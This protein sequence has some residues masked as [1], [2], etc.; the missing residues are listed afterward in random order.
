[1][2]VDQMELP[3]YLEGLQSPATTE[4]ALQYAEEH[5]APADALAFIEALP[6]AVF[7]SEDGMRRAFAAIARGEMPH[8][9]ADD[10][11]VSEDGD[12]S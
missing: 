8:Y 5:G 2:S 10:A 6:A 12:A 1:M 11:Q 7:S 3:A 9:D 4:D